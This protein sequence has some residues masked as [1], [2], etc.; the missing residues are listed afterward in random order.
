MVS[1]EI[2]GVWGVTA[3]KASMTISLIRVQGP[4]KD[5]PA[6]Q[7]K[8]PRFEFYANTHVDGS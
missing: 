8:Y 5:S 4:D 7:K 2:N 3:C 1:F 6:A